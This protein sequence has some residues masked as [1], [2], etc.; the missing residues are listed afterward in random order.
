VGCV[1]PIHPLTGLGVSS[2]GCGVLV[3]T[4][5]VLVIVV[6]MMFVLAA[7]NFRVSAS[8]PGVFLVSTETR[9]FATDASALRKFAAYWRVIYPGSALIGA[10]GCGLSSGA[11]NA[12]RRR[13]QVARAR[14]DCGASLRRA[15]EGVCPHVASGELE[16]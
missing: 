1:S 15:D 9:V 11:R 2:R 4:V 5:G 12:R 6:G 3:L 8:G 7:I 16:Q 13:V 10:C 14:G